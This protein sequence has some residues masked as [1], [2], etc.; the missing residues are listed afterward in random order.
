MTKGPLPV[1]FHCA[2]LDEFPWCSAFGEETIPIEIASGENDHS[3][4]FEGDHGRL[5]KQAT[6]S[7]KR[8]I[9]ARHGYKLTMDTPD[10]PD[11]GKQDEIAQRYPQAADRK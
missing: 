5:F 2:R 7:E 8:A 4:P 1:C 10:D 6:L 11:T 3:A 9:N